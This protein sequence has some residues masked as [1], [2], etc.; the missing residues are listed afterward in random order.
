MTTFRKFWETRPRTDYQEYFNDF[1]RAADY[2]AF[3][4]VVEGLFTVGPARKGTLWETTAIPEI[5]A[6]AAQV[7]AILA[8]HCDGWGTSTF[9]QSTSGLT[10]K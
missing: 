5:R 1:L 7:A 10:P 2:A 4:T 8:R 3:G 9:E 6:Q